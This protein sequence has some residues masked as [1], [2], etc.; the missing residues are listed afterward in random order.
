MVASR[1]PNHFVTADYLH[2]SDGYTVECFSRGEGDPVVVV[3]SLAGGVGLLEPL[4]E[5]LAADHRVITYQLRGESESFFQRGY[6]FDQLVTDLDHLI[7]AL[8]LERPGVIGSSFGGAIA[9]SYAVRN[10][11]RLGYLV[12]QGV[13]RDYRPGLMGRVAR[14]VLE[15]LPLPPDHPFINQ[16]FNVLLG[17]RRWAGD[18]FDFVV[19]RA[20]TTDQCVMSHRLEL[21]DQYLVADRLINAQ[22][23]TLILSGEKDVVAPPA[24]CR[25]LARQ[26]PSAEYETLSDAGHLAF[27]THARAF[28]DHVRRFTDRL[29]PASTSTR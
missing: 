9:L 19:E 26:L 17:G 5:A 3:P 29:S 24:D 23:P 2:L 7:T 27:V 15:R 20:W 16:F 18:H 11:H 22:T 28:A 25:Q 6:G 8:G 1:Y 13:T 12:L 14:E 10:A 21:L 4:V